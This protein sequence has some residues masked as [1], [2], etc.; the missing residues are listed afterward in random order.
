M[1]RILMMTDFSE[2]YGVKLLQG[3]LKYSHEHMPWVVGRIPL[4]F[5][6]GNKL[7]A[8][9]D[10]AQHWKADAILGQFRSSEDVRVFQERGIIPIAQD[11]LQSIPGIVNITGDYTNAGRMAARYFMEKGLRHFAFY[12]LR[13]IIWSDG[14]REGFLEEA[15]K[16]GFPLHHSDI[17]EIKDIN[18]SWWYNADKLTHWLRSLPKPVGILCCDDNRAYNIWEACA[19]SQL[20]GLR[21]PDDIMVLGVDNDETVCR[22][23]QPQLSS[24]A[25][26]VEAGGYQVA[27]LLEELLNL[28]PE[29]RKAEYKDIVVRPTHV[30]TRA[31]TDTLLHHNPYIARVLSYITDHLDS[32]INVDQLVQLVPMSRRTLEESFSREMGSSIYQYIIQSRVT[33]FQ[34]LLQAGVSPTQAATELGMEYKALSRE[35]KRRTGLSPKEYNITGPGSSRR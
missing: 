27:A 26:D 29:K 23:C 34:E 17:L 20:S 22:L 33:R 19:S 11:Y 32:R 9:A 21:I 16:A 30:V 6:D 24:V 2:S 28:P 15:A 1:A 31:S 3:I 35:F 10:I 5:R 8:A 14:R 18:T 4:S 7:H 25:L 12:G 13:E